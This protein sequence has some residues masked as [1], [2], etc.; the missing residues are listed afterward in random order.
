MRHDA[1]E[2]IPLF[3]LEEVPFILGAVLRSGGRLRKLHN[4]EFENHISDRLRALLDRDPELRDRP[5]EVRRSVPLY[6]RKRTREK[7]LGTPDLSFEYST[8][9]K[10]PW[11][12]FAIEAKR[13]HVPFP[14]GWQS[15]VAEYVTGAQGMMCFIEGRYSS[16]LASGGMLGYVFDGN[17]NQAQASVGAFIATNHA[18]L[19][20]ATTPPFGRSP[21]LGGVS[22][23]R[24]SRSDREFCIYHV[25]L[26]V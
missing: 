15:L 13:L 6:D 10:K 18:Q 19:K 21:S 23:S 26:T 1:D 8:A 2:W 5:V 25:F 16:G 3:P 24:H 17:V 7:Q 14:S 4:T 9:K 11:P 12:Y 22:E 20:C